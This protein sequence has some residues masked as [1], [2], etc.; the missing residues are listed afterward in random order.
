MPVKKNDI[1]I[2][3]LAAELLAALIELEDA[4]LIYRGGT[5]LAHGGYD[6]GSTEVELP[7]VVTHEGR[8][9][10]S[11]ARGAQNLE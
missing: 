11:G 5:Q 1:S 4:G 6:E 2:S 8:Q 9:F 3:P 10:I 7:P